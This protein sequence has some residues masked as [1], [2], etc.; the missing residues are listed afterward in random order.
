MPRSENFPDEASSCG[1]GFVASLRNRADHSNLQ[2]GLK[3]L[4]NLEHRGGS[5]SDLLTSDGA[6]IM[7][8][9]PWHL[10][11]IPEGTAV[12]N[13]FLPRDATTRIR[14]L[15]V[16]EEV[17]QAHGLDILRYRELPLKADV[18]SDLC[19]ANRPEM[20]MAFIRRPEPC[21][22]RYSF[23]K[24]LYAAKQST[25]SRL[26][27]LGIVQQF[28]FTS[29][30]AGTIVYKA[31][32]PSRH[33]AEF[34]Q[35]LKN[36]LYK[37]RFTLV[38][39]R[40]S[41]NTSTSWD[42]AQPFRMVGH[43][44]EINT[45]AGNR[46]WAYARERALGLSEDELL[47]HRGISDSGSVNEMLEALMFRS[48]IPHGEDILAIM[49][50]RA[51]SANP[52]Y[53]FWGR[54][55]EP[56]DGPALF[57]YSDGRRVGARLDRSGF[58]PCRWARTEDDLYLSSEAGSFGIPEDSILAKGSLSGGRSVSVDLRTGRVSFDDA[59]E[60][61]ENR[62][63][64]FDPRV[65]KVAVSEC[66]ETTEALLPRLALFG[67]TEEDVRKVILPT[68]TEGKEPIGSMGDTARLAALSGEPRS[69]FDFF[70]QHFAQV[71]NPPL[72]YLRER[73]VTDMSVVLGRKPNI[74]E[75][76]ELIPLRRGLE[77]D[78]PV[79]SLGTMEFLRSLKNESAESD[80]GVGTEIFDTTFARADGLAGFRSRLEALKAQAR[81]AV[82]RRKTIFLLS[83]RAAAPERPA[84]PSVLVLTSLIQ[85]LN[86]SGMRL[87]TS[88]VV[89]SGEV[90]STHHIAVL[91]G[92]GAAA[93]C[94]YLALELARSRDAAIAGPLASQPVDA[95]EKSLIGAWEQGLLKIL[96]KMGVSVLQSYQGSGL[97]TILGLSRSMHKEFFPGHRSWMSGLTLG[98]II[99]ALLR[100]TSPE[101]VARTI[102]SGKLVHNHLY[103]ENARAE[104]GESHSM[105]APRSKIIHDLV[106]A[107]AGAISSI[108]LYDAYL[109][110]TE[111]SSPVS[112]RH[113]VRP[114]VVE[115]AL[116]LERVEAP[117]AI[118]RRFGAGA[119]SFG[120]ISAES[121]RDIIQAMRD[122]G[123]RSNSGEGGENPY[124]FVDGTQAHTKQVASGRFGVTAEYLISGEEIQ[125]KIAQGA[126]PGEGGQLMAK[127]VGPE[128][129]RARFS[130][131][132]VDLISPP[133]MHDIYSIEDLKQLIFELRQL[134]PDGR[135]SVKLVSGE[136]V[137]TVA[138]GV[139]KAGADIIH[140][141]GH[142]GGTGAATLGSMKH[143]GLPWE[144]GLVDCHRSLLREGLRHRVVLRVDG[145]LA[146]GRDV[147]TAAMLGAEE[148]DFGKLLLV[149]Q[150]CVMARVCEKNTCPAGIATHDP[151][152][153]KRYEGTP[154]KIKT[155]MGYLAEDVRRHLAAAGAASIQE[156]VGRSDLLEA[157]PSH[158]PLVEERGFDLDLFLDRPAP[159]G[160]R[161]S[162][163]FVEGVSELNL[164]L[165]EDLRDAKE[166]G[167][168][169]YSV[170]PADRAILATVN[171]VVA[172][173]KAESR[174]KGGGAGSW[175]RALERTRFVF[176]GSA[177]QGFCVFL[178]EGFDVR[179]EGEANDSVAK[180][181]SGGHLVAVPT[182]S[183]KVVAE[184]NTILG[185]CA[186]YGATG[187][188][189]FARGVAGDRFAVRNSG[190]TAVIEGAGI[191]AC[192]YMT[193][194]RVVILGR[195]GA[196]VGAGMTG[197]TLFLRRS[198]VPRLNEDCVFATECTAEDRVEL[199]GLLEKY[200]AET[201]STTASR[202][203]ADWEAYA[204]EFV[205]VAPI[206]A[207]PVEKYSRGDSS[208]DE[209]P[210]P[211]IPA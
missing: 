99:Q 118:F 70:F 89:E 114:K 56:W 27:Q 51:D 37:T 2:R 195:V 21:T 200:L 41:T 211:E 197:G 16:F 146:T 155:L 144:L 187:G 204:D 125:I 88:L 23:E 193:R 169:R 152:F 104:G 177:G 178:Q 189:L 46:A 94:P 190:A 113:L 65:R 209:R 71:T 140:V 143:A 142:D 101:A 8:D 117:G 176:E 77:L 102:A 85:A 90:K 159:V 137:G 50:P 66:P 112:F 95:R 69:L 182:A 75:P 3:A 24:L 14:S 47:T 82:T 106:E 68:V 92:F 188:T 93:V 58:R 39:R 167:E 210:M 72:D 6:G 73:T 191:H 151:R 81:D 122:L 174:R 164:R 207:A 74:F 149:A 62:Y 31:L 53:R 15:R 45:I 19:K 84:L 183:S 111:E 158:V 133:P 109:R 64:S 28:F 9:I 165:F 171:G 12:A 138:V 59:S 26:R 120:A 20:L 173:E 17:F 96:S 124:Y 196:N 52:F 203:L 161:A 48:S 87:R 185:N 160:E 186:L 198:E 134:K 40:F 154:A 86:E 126:K 116:P 147:V 4:V 29:L 32:T 83:D 30:S 170:T 130:D 128:T 172:R 179:L 145:G 135:V 63:A 79:L 67:F 98:S 201:G 80:L 119:M 36:P 163:P 139:A 7:T 57:A 166:G 157:H 194:G 148:F 184:E 44:G 208:L 121:Q 38:H 181:M 205:K 162:N 1:V 5:A 141:A 10:F 202:L 49:M 54:A 103:R 78:G 105:T 115:A 199:R 206:R 108:E 35:D 13:L 34:Y 168:L 129:A 91:I 192:E 156:I 43:N 136:N 33:L 107:G 150:G 60:A 42:K 55:M 22:T 25:R 61:R 11:G 175:A 127:K 131:E 18:L 100:N 123:A 132:N 153:K 180:S 110:S 97:F 76:K